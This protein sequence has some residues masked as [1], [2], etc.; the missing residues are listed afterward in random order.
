MDPARLQL[1]IYRGRDYFKDLIFQDGDGAL[2][3]I[4]GYVFKAEIRSTN[5]QAGTLL[6]TFTIAVD[7][8]TSTITLSLTNTQT[9]L[10]QEGVA[11]WDLL[12]VIGDDDQS[13]V[14]GK[15]KSIGTITEV[16]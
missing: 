6:T 8:E 5:C 14:K 12:V 3:D 10:I 2:L 4:S 15:V 1:K 16:S 9:L 7:T 11:Y 13:Y